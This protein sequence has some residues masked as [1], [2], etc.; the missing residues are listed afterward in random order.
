MKMS[1]V[2][3]QIGAVGWSRIFLVF[4]V[5]WLVILIF[6]ALPMFTNHVLPGDTKTAERLARALV[7]LEALRKQNSELH[8][9]FRDINIGDLKSEEKE[10]LKNF[11]ARLTKADQ[12]VNNFQENGYISQKVEPN[13]QYE[14][15]RRRIT[16]N[17]QEFWSFV[18]NEVFKL[19]KQINDIAPE[20]ASSFN[21]ILSLGA[22]HKRSLLHDMN[23]LA[24]VDG[25]T[26][27]REKESNELS[28]MVQSRFQYLQNPPDCNSAKKLVCSLNKGCGYG[29]QLHHVVYC[30]MVAYGT[31]RTLVLKS[32]G[33]KYHK[34][35]WEEIFK[36]LSETCTDFSGDTSKS[37][38]GT[39]DTQVLT[40][41]IIDSISPRPPYLPL[42]IPEDLGSRL[43]RLHGDPTVWWT[44]QI[45]KFLLRP[46]QKTTDLIQQ[47]ITSLGFKR[48]IVGVHVRRTDKVGTEAAFHSIDEYMAVVDEY[49]NQLELTSPVNQRRIYLATDDPKVLV[50]AKAKYPHYEIL[51]D[52]SVSKTAA[53]S[54]RYSDSSLKGIILDIHMLA[55]S[56][57]LVCTFSSQVCRV[58]Y[59]IM[60]SFY[61]DAA[62]KFRSLDDIYY[63]GG[64]SGHNRVAVLPHE[65]Q[66][67]GEIS[68]IV[69][70]LV[71]V[72]GNHWNGYSK[73]RN[74]R[75]NQI[76]LYPSFKVRDRIELAK[77]PTY[78]DADDIRTMKAHEA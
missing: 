42:A 44:G 13:I 43:I 54:T 30:F 34:A 10:A 47:A 36:P 62:D 72:A 58:A 48:P 33:W 61:P 78:S 46:Q 52:S 53:V 11:Q 3:R 38:P 12:A 74:L 45:L 76:G 15:M 49:Y 22:E 4:I 29:C 55:M 73:G 20:M 16:T 40:L 68:L 26:T 69:G 14:L 6:A 27:W 19:Q 24:D 5:V 8:E 57:Y 64:Q 1:A 50:D 9:L 65:P 59:E 17:I 32:K 25:Y 21:H 31:E 71:G 51:G 60:Q 39:P 18:H 28:E 35:G 23:T 7:D 75:T 77:Y 2:L 70:D 56:D 67:Q 41:P 66:R 63:Y 37:W